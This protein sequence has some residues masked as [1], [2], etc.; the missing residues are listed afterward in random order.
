[1]RSL[2]TLEIGAVTRAIEISVIS[3]DVF[4]FH[5]DVLV[6]KYA[7][8]LFGGD[9]E[10][11][12]RLTE[13]GI[14][15]TL[16]KPN[17]FTFQDT[18][19]SMYP[20]NILFVGVNR[21]LQ[22]QYQEIRNFA[23]RA[24]TFLSERAPDAK[25]VALT[26][27]GPGYG[28]DESEAFKSE[29]AGVVEA[30]TNGQFPSG[31]ASIVFVEFSADRADRLAQLLKTLVPRGVLTIDG[32]GSMTRLQDKAQDTL[33]TAGYASATKAHV[34]VAMPFVPDL[35]DVFHYGIQSAVNAVGLLCER[36][37]STAFTGDILEWVKRRISS[38]TLVIADLSSAN[39]N[40]YLEVGYAWGCKKSTILLVRDPKE[41][42]FDARGQRCLV[43]K[44]SIQ[45]L[46][47]LLKKELNEILSQQN[48]IP[49]VARPD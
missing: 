46:E 27:H 9:N 14:E 24:L 15:L 42:K 16:P 38:A 1:M 47:E 12:R 25:S 29:L 44:S 22:F 39:P 33:R 10:A 40:V 35:D 3:G 30:L 41:L 48:E 2:E 8:A 45:K 5:S 11:F 32:P 28:L 7:Q 43:Y 37:D 17:E 20:K 23:R 6:L 26:I 21:L 19:K 31:L 34:F 13:A 36:G 49:P 4:S 18:G